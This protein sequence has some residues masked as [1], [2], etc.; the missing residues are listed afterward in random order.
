ME[1]NDATTKR[2]RG[3]TDAPAPALELPV[4]SMDPMH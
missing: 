3:E 1:G 2:E 4:V